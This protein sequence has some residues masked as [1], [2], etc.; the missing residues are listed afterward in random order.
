MRPRLENSDF[1]GRT[2]SQG[3]IFEWMGCSVPEMSLQHF[4]F[5][6][7]YLESTT[8]QMGFLT[9]GYF[10]PAKPRYTCA[11]VNFILSQGEQAPHVTLSA[12]LNG[13][14]TWIEPYKEYMQRPIAKP[15]RDYKKLSKDQ[16]KA[17]MQ[18]FVDEPY[19]DSTTYRRLSEGLNLTTEKTMRWFRR[20]RAQEQRDLKQ[21]KL[22][23]L[24]H[25]AAIE[26]AL[27]AALAG[28]LSDT[29][30]TE[31]AG[32]VPM[33]TETVEG[34][35]MEPTETV[36]A[37]PQIGTATMKETEIIN[38]TPKSG[39]AARAEIEYTEKD[40]EV[41]PVGT[42]FIEKGGKVLRRSGR[43]AERTAV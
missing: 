24:H 5:T 35:A 22:S 31:D 41:E 42:F 28:C 20:Q 10:E 23:M 39:T 21:Q 30:G 43:Q 2:D 34:H 1:H 14:G 3:Y 16:N 19:P 6:N 38:S 33:E 26:A 12:D 40:R 27:V 8:W 25:E 17:L 18:H 29:L 11:D 9:T 15:K 13:Y 7:N 32:T 37:T 36:Y 4:L